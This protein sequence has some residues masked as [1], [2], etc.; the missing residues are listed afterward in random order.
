M[1]YSFFHPIPIIFSSLFLQVGDTALGM[2]SLNG[3]EGV[4]RLLLES[5]AKDT[6]NKVLLSSDSYY[7]HSL[8]YYFHKMAH[9]L[10]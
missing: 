4:V 8:K 7:Y 9:S 1:V 10:T 3:H 2:A 6:P 5:G